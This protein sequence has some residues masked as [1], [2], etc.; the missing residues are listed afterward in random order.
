[1]VTSIRAI[2]SNGQLKLLDPVEF[3]EQEEVELVFIRRANRE[4][5]L[6]DIEKQ[7]STTGLLMD[8]SDIDMMDDTS[9]FVAENRELTLA[10]VDFLL[11]EAGVIVEVDIP[12]DAEELTTE[13]REG[14]GR[15][16]VSDRPVEDLIDEDRGKY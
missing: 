2:Y 16:F 10:E 11:R 9:N 8:M 5:S 3:D 6:A 1:M 12:E 15:L 7:L 14:I 4:L 13:E